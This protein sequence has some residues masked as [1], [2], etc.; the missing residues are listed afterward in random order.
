MATIYE[1][2]SQEHRKVKDVFT[3]LRKNGSLSDEQVNALLSEVREDLRL[4]MTF[5]EETFYPLTRRQ[6]DM[7]NAVDHYYNEHQQLRDLIGTLAGSGKGSSE[8]NATLDQIL[9]AL[10]QHVHDEE[11]KM[12]LAARNHI[13]DDE[14][15]RL[16]AEYQSQ[17][18]AA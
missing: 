13:G 18:P 15:A 6:T 12:F 2:L 7:G 17:K 8:W 1:V 9:G 10:D 5:E 14:A 3:R 4:H 11:T 16:A